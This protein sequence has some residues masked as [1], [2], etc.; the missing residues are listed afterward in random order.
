MLVQDGARGVIER[1]RRERGLHYNIG[2]E[3][4][5]VVDRL[6]QTVKPAIKVIST[7]I[8]KSVF[9][10][11]FELLQ[12]A[13]DCRYAESVT[14]TVECFVG[15][16]GIVFSNNE[17]FGFSEEDVLSLCEVGASTKPKAA[18]LHASTGRKGD[19]RRIKIK[20]TCKQSNL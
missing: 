18:D 1:L 14:P 7:D 2:S 11:F 8:Y 3:E 9:R 19:K 20:Q 13:D 15:S 10:T 6:L 12:N 17:Q 4:R 16:R 5:R